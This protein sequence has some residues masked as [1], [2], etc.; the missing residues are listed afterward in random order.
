M[1]KELALALSVSNLVQEK[2]EDLKPKCA[3]GRVF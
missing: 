1:P 3:S 2:P